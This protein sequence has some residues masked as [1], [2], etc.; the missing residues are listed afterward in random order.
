MVSHPLHSHVLQYDHPSAQ[1]SLLQNS[2]QKMYKLHRKLRRRDIRQQA[3]WETDT[4]DDEGFE[5]GSSHMFVVPVHKDCKVI[6]DTL[7]DSSEAMEPLKPSSL[8]LAPFPISPHSKLPP[9]NAQ[10]PPTPPHVTSTDDPTSLHTKPQ[11]FPK[12]DTSK[13]P[14]TYTH[15]QKI[16]INHCTYLVTK[17]LKPVYKP[18]PDFSPNTASVKKGLV[19][20]IVRAAEVS[21]PGFR[22]SWFWSPS[23]QSNE[24]QRKSSAP[25]AG[26][27]EGVKQRNGDGKVRMI[28]SVSSVGSTKKVEVNKTLPTKVVDKH[29]SSSS[30][31][32]RTRVNS[33]SSFDNWDKSEPV[34][35]ANPT[36]RPQQH[37]YS[38]TFIS[39]IPVPSR[40]KQK[41]Q[42]VKLSNLLKELSDTKTTFHTLLSSTVSKTTAPS[43]SLLRVF[44]RRDAEKV[45]VFPSDK[46]L[47]VLRL[48]GGKSQDWIVE[49]RWERMIAG[50]VEWAGL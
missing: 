26:K 41:L 24:M 39:K 48:L 40:P 29:S 19:V 13:Q 5:S 35:A 6:L 7:P 46:V 45:E 25:R 1:L 8:L 27:A 23:T 34:A 17:I 28:S 12:I 31:S 2:S 14:F 36:T 10:K 20:P 11:S 44:L 38:E 18:L 21:V 49:W 3:G 32:E 37:K 50:R 9:T 33:Q 42:E 47:R 22:S 16:R 30:E 15:H 43:S 4:D